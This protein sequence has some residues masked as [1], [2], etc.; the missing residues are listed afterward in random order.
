MEKGRIANYF[1]QLVLKFSEVEH[2]LIITLLKG[3]KKVIGRLTGQPPMLGPKAS[4]VA[5]TSHQG[6][7]PAGT[8]GTREESPS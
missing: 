1:L 3:V 4:D 2:I 7:S 5:R 6:L 8:D